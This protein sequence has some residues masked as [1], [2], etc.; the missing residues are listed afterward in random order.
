MAARFRIARDLTQEGRAGAW[1]NPRR[2]AYGSQ[3][4]KSTQSQK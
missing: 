4:G 3:I 1:N 2:H